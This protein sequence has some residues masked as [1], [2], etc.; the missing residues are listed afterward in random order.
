MTKKT[1]LQRVDIDLAKEMRELAKLRYFKNLAKKEPS[2]AEMTK[3]LR[4]TNGWNICKEELKT[5]PKR[6]DNIWKT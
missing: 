3:L 5:K 1:T 4:R 2:F 6:E